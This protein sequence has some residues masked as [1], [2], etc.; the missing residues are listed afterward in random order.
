MLFLI[1]A[2]LGI[3]TY[4]ISRIVMGFTVVTSGCL[5]LTAANLVWI[6]V[7]IY[8]LG[9]K[10]RR[11]MLENPYAMEQ[12]EPYKGKYSKKQRATYMAISYAIT[13]LLITVSAFLVSKELGIL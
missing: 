7:D 3:A 2:V 8:V 11:K 9:C 13:I 6:G 1:K 12:E 4:A 10:L 5:G